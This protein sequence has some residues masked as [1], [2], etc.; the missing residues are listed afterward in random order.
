MNIFII[1]DDP[2]N[3]KLMNIILA[4]SGHTL[5][6]CNN[7][8]L[9]YDRI[10]TEMPDLI[11]MD[12]VLP[13][14]SGTA[15]ASKLKNDAETANIPIIAIT[16]YP[17]KF[18]QKDIVFTGFDAYIVKPINTRVLVDMVEGVIPRNRRRDA[19]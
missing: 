11:L 3:M 7:A 17:E 2:V 12:L 16:G 10:K 19:V 5:S 1:E 6:D 9:A 8:G 14:M 15:L 18:R 4:S 13:E